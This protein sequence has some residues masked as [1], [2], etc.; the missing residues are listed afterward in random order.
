MG[1]C[2]NLI[3][4]MEVARITYTTALS[5]LYIDSMMLSSNEFC[6][7]G[8]FI[9]DPTIPEDDSNAILSVIVNEQPRYSFVIHLIR[10]H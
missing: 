4:V 10:K 9:P 6:V 3:A 2:S 5:Q 8:G 7:V 1:V